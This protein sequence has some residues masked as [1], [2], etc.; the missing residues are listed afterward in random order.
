MT[1]DMRLR[2]VGVVRNQ[3]KEMVWGPGS[4]AQS[5]REKVANSKKRQDEISEIEI[6]PDLD[7]ILDGIEEYSHL[8]VLYWADR[9][10]AEN[11]P[12]LK[13]HPMGREDF[14]LVGIFATRSPIRPNN[15]LAA[16]VRMVEHK[17][18]VLRVTGLD[19]LDGSPVIDIKPSIPS[20]CPSGEMRMARW[21]QQIHREFSEIDANGTSR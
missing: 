17:G 9:I 7:G 4:S 2:S 10:P 5:W 3:Q 14:P 12:A 8:L 20:D 21:Q 18:N 11:S 6:S 13:V 19:A 16:V 1:Q 15:I